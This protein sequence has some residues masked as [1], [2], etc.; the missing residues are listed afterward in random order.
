MR[1]YAEADGHGPAV[2]LVHGFTQTRRCWGPVA[3]D[4]AA[5]HEVTRVDA[6][7]HG[8]SA[9][10]SV[11]LTEGAQLIGDAGA[12]ATYVGY[13][14]G[15]R[16]CLHL[17]LTNPDLVR[18]LVLI[19]GT[20][21]IENARERSSRR[22][23][24]LETAARIRSQGIEAFLTDWLD[25]PIFAHLPA[26]AQLRAERLENTAEGLAS[27]I[28]LAGTG[29]QE[30]LWERLSDLTMPVLLV[31]GELDEKFT[32][33]A[34]QMAL[35]TGANATVAVIAHAGHAAHLEQPGAVVVSLRAWLTEHGL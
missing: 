13:S 30:P 15:A 17:A 35:R 10:L 9:S 7:G 33:I 19:G 8:R 20:A 31:V 18:G 25:Q 26:D 22:A 28:E 34:H 21:G 4:L 24:D 27:S 12:T 11:G 2:V 1:L 32:R 14:M 5:D 3:A 6:P 29:S 16:F 23:Q